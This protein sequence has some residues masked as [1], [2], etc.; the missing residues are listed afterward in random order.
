MKTRAQVQ[1]ALFTKH[2]SYDPGF[3]KN[4]DNVFGHCG[5]PLWALWT[6][7]FEVGCVFFLAHIT[8]QFGMETTCN[9]DVHSVICTKRLWTIVIFILNVFLTLLPFVFVFFWTK[10]MLT[11]Q[12]YIVHD[13]FDTVV[14]FIFIFFY[15]FVVYIAFLH[16]GVQ[17]VFQHYI[18]YAL[19]AWHYPYANMFTKQLSKN[20]LLTYWNL[21]VISSVKNVSCFFFRRVFFCVCVQCV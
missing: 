18:I 2:V 16:H 13:S 6:V 5:Q 9:V 3:E 19:W 17:F 10:K 21:H 1:N 20:E 14:F 11:I 8:C 4:V 15:H 12:N 7:C